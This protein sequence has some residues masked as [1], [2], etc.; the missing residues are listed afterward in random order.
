MNGYLKVS[1]DSTHIETRGGNKNGK[2]WEISTQSV[3]A[4]LV[5][6]TGVVD[7]FP[8]KIDFMLEKGARAYPVGEYILN[9]S[10]FKRGDFN[11]LVLS[12]P[13][14]YPLPVASVKAA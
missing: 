1:V 14:L 12:R 6:A 7:K 11:S 5:D 4:H 10:S 3:W 8:S 13:V 2:D 9:P